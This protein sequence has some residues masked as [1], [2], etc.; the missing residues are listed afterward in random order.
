ME[1]WT[2]R[3]VHASELM[4]EK[5]TSKKSVC[6]GGTLPG[7]GEEVEEDKLGAARGRPSAPTDL[8]IRGQRYYFRKKLWYNT[9]D[10]GTR[11]HKATRAN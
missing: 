9:L 6:M 1:R 8:G 3:C 4:L 10:R 2:K 11:G 7:L 5:A